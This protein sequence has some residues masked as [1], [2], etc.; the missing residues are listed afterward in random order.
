M[1]IAKKCAKR[2]AIK[3]LFVYLQKQ[4]GVCENPRSL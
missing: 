3:I 1:I 2:L 4:S